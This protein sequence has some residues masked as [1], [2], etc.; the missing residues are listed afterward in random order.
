MQ[1]AP[2]WAGKIHLIWNDFAFQMQPDLKGLAA[3]F[4]FGKCLLASTN[5]PNAICSFGGS[6]A[7]LRAPQLGA[8]AIREAVARAGIPPE[9]I[10]VG[11][12]HN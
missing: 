5:Y 12:Q 6:L 2:Q 7:T 1:L 4:F 8:I 3:T 10:Q 11:L 9:M